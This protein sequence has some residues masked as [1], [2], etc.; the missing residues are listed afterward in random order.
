M[1]STLRKT[2]SVIQTFPCPHTKQNTDY[3]AKRC[4]NFSMRMAV[5]KQKAIMPSLCLDNAA[6]VWISDLGQDD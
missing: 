2:A 3:G 6:L 4:L 5:G 1:L